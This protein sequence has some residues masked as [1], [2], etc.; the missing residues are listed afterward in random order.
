FLRKVIRLNPAAASIW[1]GPD[2]HRHDLST[3]RVALEV[4]TTM[5]C[6]KNIFE[7]HGHDQLE[8]PPD[9]ILFLGT[10]CVEQAA[11]AGESL[12]ALVASIVAAGGDQQLLLSKL[13]RYDLVPDVLKQCENIC[14]T[15]QVE[16]LYAV[17]SEFPRLVSSSLVGGM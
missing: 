4:K 9:G 12:P 15:V 17:S 5:A 3:G 10:V 6:D 16:H 7:I 13:P 8:P 14:F 2:G 11:S 1:L